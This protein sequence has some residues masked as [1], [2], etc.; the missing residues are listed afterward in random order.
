MIEDSPDFGNVV[1]CFRCCI[2]RPSFSGSVSAPPSALFGAAASPS[3]ATTGPS[4]FGTISSPP[5]SSTCPNLFRTASSLPQSSTGPG[6]FGAASSP[7]THLS[8][9]PTPLSKL[10][11]AP[12]LTAS[13]QIS[14]WYSTYLTEA[15]RSTGSRPSVITFRQD[16]FT[17]LIKELSECSECRQRV[18]KISAFCSALERALDKAIGEV[19]PDVLF[20]ESRSSSIDILRSPPALAFSF[21]CAP[22]KS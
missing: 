19:N 7:V 22:Q 5:Q 20:D 17:I 15:R 1:R 11:S 2:S 18:D 4:L 16:V 14:K 6:L 3:S 13:S 10:S 9:G 21:G 12:T 8:S